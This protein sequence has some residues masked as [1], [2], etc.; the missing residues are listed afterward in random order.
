MHDDCMYSTQ[1]HEHAQEY[2]TG[3]KIDGQRLKNY[4]RCSSGRFPWSLCG[5]NLSW[6]HSRRIPTKQCQNLKRPTFTMLALSIFFPRM[7]RNCGSTWY[8]LVVCETV[9]NVVFS[10][11]P[12]V[13]SKHWGASTRSSPRHSPFVH[14]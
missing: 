14:A 3:T 2:C 8:G 12:F 1:S 7:S 4:G 9:G 5:S 13:L 11:G 6:K 10:A